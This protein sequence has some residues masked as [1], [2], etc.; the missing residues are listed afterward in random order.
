MIKVFLHKGLKELFISGSTAKIN[1]SYHDR[2]IDLLDVLNAAVSPGD[3]TGVAKFHALKGDRRGE[4]SMH[5]SGN[6]VLTF[7]FDGQDVTDVNF[8]DYH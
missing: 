8:E 2:I 4:W 1:K 3:L 6:W 5:I 7:R